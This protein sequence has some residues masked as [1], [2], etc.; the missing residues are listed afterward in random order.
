MH[1]IGLTVGDMNSISLDVGFTDSMAVG[2]GLLVQQ[3]FFEQFQISFNLDEK[4]FEVVHSRSDEK[5]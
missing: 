3:G 5:E 2:T 1:R 4:I